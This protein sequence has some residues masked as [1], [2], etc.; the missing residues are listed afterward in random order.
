MFTM[1]PSSSQTE[2]DSDCEIIEDIRQLFDEK[3]TH[4]Q[5]ELNNGNSSKN[6][7]N[8][9]RLS[10]RGVKRKLNV[11]V[12]LQNN[13][14]N[15]N[16]SGGG[17][18]NDDEDSNYNTLLSMFPDIDPA[19]IE[20]ICAEP[21]YKKVDGVSD[22][23]MLINHLLGYNGD[24]NHNPDN[25]TEVFEI[26]DTEIIEE[27]KRNEN[28]L[29]EQLFKD[30]IKKD[31]EIVNEK[32][33]ILENIFPDACPHRLRQ[34]VEVND[35]ENIEVLTDII[36]NFLSNRNYEKRNQNY[37]KIKFREQIKE[38][39][40]FFCIE[41]FLKEFPKPFDHFE[42]PGRKETFQNAALNYLKKKYLNH[43]VGFYF[44]VKIVINCFLKI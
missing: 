21:P 31:K 42:N 25:E 9:N 7:D 10:D 17:T 3:R 44:F 30:F 38:Y 22:I 36:E 13:H 11:R 15:C 18:K 14:L 32:L 20:K 27:Q 41:T 40:D 33:S 35:H 23:Q 26:E 43:P 6:F 2:C 8:S 37:A 28:I 34:I 5:Q 19:Y 12:E 29:N 24:Q 16:L 1:E 4:L 39:T